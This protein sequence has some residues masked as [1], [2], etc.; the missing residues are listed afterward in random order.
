MDIFRRIDTE[1]DCLT[2]VKELVG[3]DQLML[4]LAHRYLHEESPDLPKYDWN[5]ATEQQ[6]FELLVDLL[7]MHFRRRERIMNE[8]KAIVSIDEA[9]DASKP[10]TGEEATTRASKHPGERSEGSTNTDASSNKELAKSIAA[11]I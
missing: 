3:L 6:W 9:P 8:R 10:L 1:E 11:K 4:I 5:E 2:E 7:E